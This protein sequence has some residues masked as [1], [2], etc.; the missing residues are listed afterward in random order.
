LLFLLFLLP[1]LERLDLLDR[2]LED[3]VED[4]V[5]ALGAVIAADKYNDEVS[6]VIDVGGGNGG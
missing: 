6:S 3:P 2:E 1:R 5:P 4:G